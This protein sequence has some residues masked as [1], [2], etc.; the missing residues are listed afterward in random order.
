MNRRLVA[1]LCGFVVVCAAAAAQL[2]ARAAGR[3][4]PG[5]PVAFA[6]STSAVAH[7]DA[8]PARFTCDG[9][10]SSPALSWNE[11]PAGTKALALVCDDPDAPV[12]LWTHWLIWSLPPDRRS[13]PEGLAKMA[14][15]P[16]GLRQGTNDF[17]RPGY[18]GPC[19][20]RGATHRYFFRLLA[21]E[22]PLDLAPGADRRAFDRALRG[23]RVLASSELMGR[24]AR[25][26]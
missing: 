17:G 19:P 14:D 5:G 22:A 21:L 10:D 7:G 23:R 16:E 11:P 18:G 25:A 3:A 4:S 8:I 6:L 12:G 9:A 20:P 1:I 2:G 26:R 15:G 24:Y 13:L